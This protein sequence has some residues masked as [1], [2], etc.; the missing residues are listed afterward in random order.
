MTPWLI[1]LFAL[2]LA[3]A[4]HLRL[5]RQMVLVAQA[6][7]ELRGALCSLQLRAVPGIE[8]DVRRATL[9]L[10]DLAESNRLRRAADRRREFDLTELAACV[11]AAWRVP[12]V[13]E[14]LLV[15]ADPARV[16]QALANLVANAAEHGQGAVELTV[17][18]RDGRARVEVG[19]G[20]PGLPAAV[21]DL[22][23][24]A[25]RR[26]TPRGHGLA[27]AA[28]VAES[29][30][31]R[32]LAEHGARGASVV[33]ELPAAADAATAVTRRPVRGPLG[34]AAGDSE[35]TA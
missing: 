20:G 31:G 7:H 24:A 13:G 27:V 25:R 6:A 8:W 4:L 5:V 32:L 23:R 10:D 16:G 11:A 9:A 15:C 12:V 34:W 3:A 29:H 19:D 14:P 35:G 30:G 21:A 2:A 18:R 17:R 33:L 1:T 22:T 28:R 26:R